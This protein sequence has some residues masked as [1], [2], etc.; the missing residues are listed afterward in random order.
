MTIYI[1]LQLSLAPPWQ[2][3]KGTHPTTVNATPSEQFG[4]HYSQQDSLKL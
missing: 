3:I 2:R 1:T 4:T